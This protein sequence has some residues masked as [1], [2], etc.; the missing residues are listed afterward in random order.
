MPSSVLE[1]AVLN[2]ERICTCKRSYIDMTPKH[3]SLLI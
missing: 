2:I 3:D 1:R